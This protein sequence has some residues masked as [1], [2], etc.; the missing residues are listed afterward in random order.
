ME[1]ARK[2]D[3]SRLGERAERG[4]RGLIDKISGLAKIGQGTRVL[5]VGA[6]TGLYE[7]HLPSGKLVAL[8]YSL[9]MLT[10]AGEKGIE[11]LVCADARELPFQNEAF[12]CVLLIH[13]GSLRHSETDS[14]ATVREMKRVVR[15]QLIVVLPNQ[16]FNTMVGL[17]LHANPG[18]DKFG[19]H[20]A[21]VSKLFRQQGIKII[22]NRTFLTFDPR[23]KFRRAVDRVLSTLGINC[24]GATIITRGQV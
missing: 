16:I 17:L 24:F 12:D 23:L 19:V 9:A 13:C 10:I 6:G 22:D 5:S 18:Y 20:P 15:G 21:R 3:V 7:Q 14:V 1:F 4:R 11:N 2:F 8:D